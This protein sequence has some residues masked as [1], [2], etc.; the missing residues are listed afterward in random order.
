MARYAPSTLL[1]IGVFIV[2]MSPV[3]AQGD[4]P[5]TDDYINY[6]Q[7]VNDTITNDAFFDLWR[8]VAQRGDVL[9]VTMSASDG[10]APLIGIAGENQEVIAR[11]DEDADGNPLPSAQ[12]NETATLEFEAP[13]DGEYII[14]ATRVDNEAGTTTG[15]YTLLLR[16]ASTAASRDNSLQAVTFRCGGH[17]GTT[18]ATLRFSARADVD[19]YRVSV[20]GLDGFRPV[21]RAVAGIEGDLRDCTNDHQTMR[22]DQFT[23]PGEAAVDLALVAGDLAA[24]QLGL[25]GG[26]ALERIDFTI[27]SIDGAPG[28]YLAVIDGFQLSV[29]GTV[30][31]ME[32]LLGPLASATEMQV[33]MVKVGSSRI[34]PLLRLIDDDEDENYPTCDDAGRRGCE[35][36][37]SLVG[38][39]VNFGEGDIQIIG[40]RFDAGMRLAPGNIEPMTLEFSSRASSATGAFA[41]LIIGEL[42]AR[43][44][45]N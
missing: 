32:V 2:L 7:P 28:R 34:D 6:D 14:V 33:Y 12:P 43:E 38:A 18:A 37:P 29:P 10:L 24:A 17:I 39:G 5:I 8:L 36:V 40:T 25:R 16:R 42:P 9:V 22:D 3:H 31:I 30:V 15:S 4:D 35:D 44:V 23:L 21:I 41:V 19:T 27:G 1:V 20:Y 45:G 13:E 11:S 26:D